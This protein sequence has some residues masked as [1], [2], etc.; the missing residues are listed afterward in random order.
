MHGV[1]LFLTGLFLGGAV[2][3]AAMCLVQVTRC[4]GCRHRKASVS[5]DGR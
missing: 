3:V 2:G 1:L 4:A 5:R